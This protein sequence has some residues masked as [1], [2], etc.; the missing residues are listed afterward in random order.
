[1]LIGADVRV[2]IGS[3]ITVAATASAQIPE[4]GS[5]LTVGPGLVTGWLAQLPVQAL[6]GI[7]PPPGRS[8]ARLRHP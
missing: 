5:V 3:S 4:P 2:G 7:G 1:M 6:H 8:T